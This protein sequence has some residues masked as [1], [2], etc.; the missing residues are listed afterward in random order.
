MLSSVF[1]FIAF[2]SRKS[3]G[4]DTVNEWPFPSERY[5]ANELNKKQMK[6]IQTSALP[7]FVI[8][9]VDDMGYGD[10]GFTGHPNINTPNIDKLASDGI[11]LTTWYTGQPVCSPS[12]A[13]MLTGR[14][15][16]RSGCAGGWG[17]GVFPDGAIG[18][19]PTNESTFAS[20][21]KQAGYATKMQGKWHLGQRSQFQPQNHGFDSAYWIPYSVDMGSS[22]WLPDSRGLPLPLLNN[23]Q[24][25]QQPVDLSKVSDLYIEQATQF[26]QT[27]VSAD[28]PFL[29]YMA[30]SH[31]HVPDFT[32]TKFCNSSRRGRYGDA[33]QEVDHVIGSIYAAIEKSGVADNT[34]TFF[35]ADNGPWLQKKLSG[36][37]AGLFSMGKFTTWEGG[38]R[39]PAFAH[40]PGRIAAGSKSAEVVSTMDIFMTMVNLTASTKYLPTDDRIY[41]G[42]DMSDIIFNQNGGKSKH[43]CYAMY[44][45]AVNASNCEYNATDA[46]FVICSGIWAMRCNVPNY[47]TAYKAHWVT[48]YT[49]GK[50]A[51]ETPPLLFNIDWDPSESYPIDKTNANYQPIM[52][53]LSQKREEALRSLRPVPN[54]MELGQNTDFEICAAP[55][56][57]EK[58]PQ[59]PNCTQTVEGFTGFTCKPVCYDEDNCSGG[60]PVARDSYGSM[61]SHDPVWHVDDDIYTTIHYN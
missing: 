37:S 31:V 61:S 44:G 42:K 32:N 3:F 5:V 16:V 46:K 2:L 10:V 56:S 26:I 19:L 39:Q 22:A 40:W 30:H 12:R 51:V 1:F 49:D 17:G 23:S 34:L 50:V 36:G 7:N 6:S 59:Y 13:A 28:T 48:R 60:A 57:K 25:L 47:D 35:T 21:L 11:I 29:L 52:E 38:M 54:Q 15:P 41:D 58:Y 53:Y 27:S 18:G 43:D 55:N 9:F 33:V 24:V 4:Y 45:G 14:Y 20:V 8:F